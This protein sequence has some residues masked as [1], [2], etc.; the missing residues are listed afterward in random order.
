[1]YKNK[2]KLSEIIFRTF[3]VYQMAV[4]IKRA[5]LQSLTYLVPVFGGSDQKAQ[6]V[7]VCSG[8]F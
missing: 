3:N 6:R 4:D 1:M 5:K 2:P 8:V 7:V